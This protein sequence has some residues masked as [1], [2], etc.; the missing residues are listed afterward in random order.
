MG[1][2]EDIASNTVTSVDCNVTQI[3]VTW[4]LNEPN[5]FIASVTRLLKMLMCIHDELPT[6][7]KT[8]LPSPKLSYILMIQCQYVHFQN[9]LIALKEILCCF[10]GNLQGTVEYSLLIN[11]DGLPLFQ[12]PD[13]YKCIYTKDGM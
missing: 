3:I 1:N 11:I 6:S 12:L 5:V 2:N 10:Y 4:A 7:F 8:L 9:W 13:I